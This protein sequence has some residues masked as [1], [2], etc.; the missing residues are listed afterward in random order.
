MQDPVLMSWTI[1]ERCQE[2]LDSARDEATAD[3]LFAK[4]RCAESEYESAIPTTAAG[5]R[6][7]IRDA[8]ATLETCDDGLSAHCSSQLR[9]IDRRLARRTL[10]P[11]DVFKLR[12]V[13]NAAKL[14]AAEDDALALIRTALDGAATPRLIYESTLA[15]HL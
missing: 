1:I 15:D 3:A 5:V 7:K 10:Q 11:R 2:S 6:R 13:Y 14:R 8:I 9:A 4:M 12:T